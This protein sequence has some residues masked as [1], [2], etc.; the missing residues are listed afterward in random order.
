MPLKHRGFSNLP[1]VSSG[2][3]SEPSILAQTRAVMRL[4]PHPPPPPPPPTYPVTFICFESVSLVREHSPV[5]PCF[6]CIENVCR[7]VPCK[8]WPED[9]IHPGVSWRFIHRSSLSTSSCIDYV[10]PSLESCEPASPAFPISNPKRVWNFFSLFFHERSGHRNILWPAQHKLPLYLCLH[11]TANAVN[12]RPL[13]IGILEYE[14]ERYGMI[15]ILFIGTHFCGA[16]TNNKKK[17]WSL[18]I[19]H[20]MLQCPHLQNNDFYISLW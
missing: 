9:V 12:T 7:P 20:G 18:H 4:T 10:V 5:Y 1:I 3:F 14:I 2:T 16:C 17:F 11:S 8:S 15:K 6:V 19:Y 13:G